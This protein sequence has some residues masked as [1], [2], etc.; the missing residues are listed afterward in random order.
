MEDNNNKPKMSLKDLA[1]QLKPKADETTSAS[2]RMNEVSNATSSTPDT[3]EGMATVPEKTVT[4]PEKTATAPE[5]TA[6]APEKTATAPEKTAVP[7]GATQSQGQSVSG[8]MHQVGDNITVGG[9]NCTI[10]ECLG[11]GT[12]GEIFHVKEG[13]KNYALKLCHPGFQTNKK[14]LDALQPLKGKDCIV[15]IEAYGDT[16]ELMEFV[17]GKSGAHTNFNFADDPKHE[18]KAQTIL[19]IAYSIAMSLDKMH[20][21][22]VLHKDVKPAN[23]LIKDPNTWNCVLCDFGIADLLKTETNNGIMRKY[24]VTRRN[25]TP[26]YAAPEI[27]KEDNATMNDDG[28]ISSEMT[29]KADFYSLGMTILSMWMG[30]KAFTRA[31][32][33][34]SLRKMKGTIDIPDDIPDPLNRIVRGL[35][36]KSPAKRWDFKSIDAYLNGKD[37]PVEE[38]EILADLNIVYNASK[39]QTAHTFEDLTDFMV[40]DPDLAVRYLYKGQLN[41][42]LSDYPELQ[43][44]LEDIVENRYQTDQNGGVIAAVFAICPDKEITING[45]D[46][47]TGE[48][49]QCTANTLKD[50]SDFCNRAIPEDGFF[51]G[52]LFLEWVR[53]RDSSLA[54]ALPTTDVDIF[55]DMLRIQTIDP[56]SDINLCNDPNDPDY[57]MT[58]EGLARVINKA[59]NV[60]WNTYQGDS[61]A[62]LADIQTKDDP[63]YR[64]TTLNTVMG[65]ALNFT[66][67]EKDGDNYLADF[68]QTK[69]ARFAK[70][71]SWLESCLDIYNE[72]NQKK[73]GPKDEEYLQQVAWMRV[74]KGFGIDPVYHL[75]DEDADITTVRELFKFSKKTLKKEYE[76]RGL[77]GWLAVQHH[78]NPKVNLKPQFTYEKL[79]H[80]Y[81]EDVSKIDPDDTAV[82]R[83]EEAHEEAKRIVS[84]GKGKIGKQSRRNATQYLLSLLLGVLPLTALAIVLVVN[85]IMH[86]TID[87]SG[88][89]L[90][91]WIWPVGLVVGAILYFILD[92]DGC[93]TP[94]IIGVVGAVA[95]FFLVKFLGQFIL[96]FYLVVVLGALITFTILTVFNKSEYA[97]KARKFDKPGFEEYIL[98]PLYYAYSDEDEFDSSLNGMVDDTYIDA[99]K[100][101]LTKR[102][103]YV[104]IF[105]GASIL[106]W[107]FSLLLPRG[108]SETQNPFM[109]KIAHTLGWD[110]VDEK[111]ADVDETIAMPMITKNLQKGS[112]GEAVT[113]MQKR[114][115][116]LGYFEGEVSDTFDDA[117]R[118]AV[119]AFQKDNK[120]TADGVVGEKTLKKMFDPEAKHAG[121]KAPAQKETKPKSNNTKPSSNKNNSSQETSTQKNEAEATEEVIF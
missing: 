22:N 44:R 50:V 76:E 4:A 108:G 56:L 100:H 32:E 104:L 69:G 48:E 13:K 62:V 103:L 94:I 59:Y 61:D 113:A 58:Q 84:E 81:L 3:P 38:D 73:A 31:E 16:F 75:E 82:Q 88:I 21:A 78:E 121:E 68:M 30:E 53:T 51:S 8:F 70:Q 110:Q 96:Y 57:A 91:N 89:K 23:I 15:D 85:I 86:P 29:P 43:A 28:T 106:L 90:E 116:Q 14:V 99:W 64:K 40:D 80:E 112:K 52:T 65:I 46:R 102:R 2:E 97:K 49:V 35:L 10:T 111:V 20:E 98:E 71:L 63:R 72:D 83:F 105:I 117:T 119:K 60:W 118:T 54:D 101:D 11:S 114:L 107:S 45:I 66:E 67:P 33:E 93:L 9:H 120:L 95:L 92:T 34:N 24:C 74:I 17:E 19:L 115:K 18:K 37:V 39:H 36:I 47:T 1:S 5:R 7:E 79:L 27:Y 109:Q 12:E 55:T 25:R 6:T 87:T 77:R 26:I 42:W 41:K